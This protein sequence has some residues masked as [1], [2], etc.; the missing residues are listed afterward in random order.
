MLHSTNLATQTGAFTT[1]EEALAQTF[2][3]NRFGRRYRPDRQPLPD[4][5][6]LYKFP[7]QVLLFL[8]AG[9]REVGAFARA[10][11]FCSLK[12]WPHSAEQAAS[13]HLTGSF[14]SVETGWC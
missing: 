2:A 12:G 1:E 14:S 5:G 3:Q 6:A 13:S 10:T 8:L 9:P 11:E 4:P 7:D